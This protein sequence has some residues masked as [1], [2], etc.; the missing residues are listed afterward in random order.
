MDSKKEELAERLKMEIEMGMG[1]AGL[2]EPVLENQTKSPSS[3]GKF[4]WPYTKSI[5]ESSEK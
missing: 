1:P 4:V 5:N 2:Q 3:E